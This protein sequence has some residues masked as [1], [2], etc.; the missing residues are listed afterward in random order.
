M[1]RYILRIDRGEKAQPKTIEFE[2]ADPH[3]AF[4]LL[5]R[6][7]GV[8]SASLWQDGACLGT[9]RRKGEDFWELSGQEAPSTEPSA[10]RPA[11]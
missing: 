11:S 7:R 8:S 10:P 1:G 5:G 9:L 3:Q 6:E 4:A 2:G